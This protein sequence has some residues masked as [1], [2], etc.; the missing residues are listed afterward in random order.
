[1]STHKIAP[2]SVD[3]Q[4]FAQ[5][6]QLFEQKDYRRALTYIDTCLA[7]KSDDPESRLLKIEL[8]VTQKD[9]GRAIMLLSEWI[10]KEKNPGP[11]IKTLHLLH[12]KA[13]YQLVRDAFKS[14]R[15]KKPKE[16]ELHLY[17]ADLLLRNDEYQLAQEP[18][19]SALSLTRD[20][21]LQ[22]K[23]LF[24]QGLSHYEQENYPAARNALEKAVKLGTSYPPA[25][26]LLAY[27][28]AT[29]EKNLGYAQKL[30][31]KALAIDP[32]N[33][34]FKDTQALIAYKKKNYDHAH[35]L[36]QEIARL[37]PEDCTIV[38]HLAKVQR[39]KGNLDMALQTIKIAQQHA[40]HEKEKMKIQKLITKWSNA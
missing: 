6:T 30:I 1:M 16:L 26:N 10:E 3:A 24:Q 11:W 20:K 22:T 34:H 4:C 38:T 9:Y 33:P 8:L 28:Y 37:C 5:A 40:L 27:Y 32:D 36:I 21:E 23:I 7:K 19:E 31:D 15:T 2:S 14:L 12:A 17:Y 29:E 13:P 25:H 35:T 18:L 39:K